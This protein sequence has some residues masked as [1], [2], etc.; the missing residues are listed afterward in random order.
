MQ[1][2]GAESF[3]RW[4]IFLRSSVLDAWRVFSSVEGLSACAADRGTIREDF[5][6]SSD[7]WRFEFARSIDEDLRFDLAEGEW[8]SLI[9]DA[10]VRSVRQGHLNERTNE[11]KMTT[12]MREIHLEF[13]SGDPQISLCSLSFLIEVK[14]ME[15]E[16]E[17]ENRW[18]SSSRSDSFR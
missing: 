2:F 17:N 7:F 10:T 13:C 14:G 9:A 6:W 12:P 18:L 11:E 1:N 4:S 16:R 15:K 5:L 8:R 3:S